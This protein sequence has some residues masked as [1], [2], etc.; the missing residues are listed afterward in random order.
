MNNFWKGK[1]VVITGAAGF[2]GSNVVDTLT[3]KESIITA[4]VSPMTSKEKIEKNLM[5]SFKNINLQRAD[6]T[7]FSDCLKI[8]RGQDIVLHFAAMD[9]GKAF[10][11][12]YS[13]EIFRVNTQMIL[14]M[15]EASRIEH[16]MR[17]LLP[18]SIDVYSPTTL[19]I[20]KDDQAP[21]GY[22]WSK[23]VGELVAKMYAKEY[24]LKIAIARPG[25]VYGPRDYSSGEKQRAIPTFIAHCL[26]GEKIKIWDDVNAKRPFLYITDLIDVLLKLTE[27][28][29]VCDP[30]NIASER[31]ISL[32]D[33]ARLIGTIAQRE[34]KLQ[35]EKNASSKE[36]NININIEK[37]KKVISFKERV[38]LEKGLKLTIE[39]YRKAI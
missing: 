28:Y 27:L 19:E 31:T 18:S 20:L 26:R 35:F 17:F 29:A 6:L 8:I 9:G 11:M 39:Y 5:L 21:D 1:K 22:K 32:P 13:A 24:G 37:A 4:V 36:N 23:T 16:V 7:I 3:K 38:G 15:L 2:I 30:I 14:N 12:K 33:L 34:A 10:K 25:N